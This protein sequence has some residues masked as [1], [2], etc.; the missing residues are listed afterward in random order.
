VANRSDNYSVSLRLRGLCLNVRVPSVSST[1][2]RPRRS[3]VTVFVLATMLR[4]LLAN[5][6]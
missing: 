4:K 1:K 6:T 5:G 2:K 3:A